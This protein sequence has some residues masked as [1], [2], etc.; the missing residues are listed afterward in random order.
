MA[1]FGDEPQP[2]YVKQ[3]GTLLNTCIFHFKEIIPYTGLPL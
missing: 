3:L 2:S 1:R